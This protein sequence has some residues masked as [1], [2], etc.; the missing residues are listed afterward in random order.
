[1]YMY[2]HAY[3]CTAPVHTVYVRM[4]IPIAIIPVNVCQCT[5]VVFLFTVD[6]GNYCESS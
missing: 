1:M 4:C 6:T 2:T 5:T 3:T